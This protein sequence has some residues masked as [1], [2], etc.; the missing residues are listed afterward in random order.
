MYT[1]LFFFGGMGW[2]GVGKH[3]YLTQR[4]LIWNYGGSKGRNSSIYR[5][6]SIHQDIRGASECALLRRG[7]WRN[8]LF[9]EYKVAEGV[10]NGMEAI[11]VAGVGGTRGLRSGWE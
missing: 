8:R 11:I 3:L 7:I 4:L 9:D 10:R 1:L 2:D 5:D 6:M